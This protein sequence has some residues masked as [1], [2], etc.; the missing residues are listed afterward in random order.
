MN[1]EPRG[2]CVVDNNVQMKHRPAILEPGPDAFLANDPEP[3]VRPPR[4][5]AHDYVDIYFK[6][7]HPTWPFLHRGTFD[8]STEPCVLIQSIAM[9]GLWM[10]G[11]PKS[12]DAAMDFHNSLCS[13]IRT[14]MDR[15]QISDM[16]PRTSWPIPTYQSILLQIIFALFRA[17]KRGALDLNFRYLI[18]PDVYELLVAL[19]R[20]CRLGGIFSYPNMIT[21][22]S[23]ITTPALLWV[24]VEEIKRFG[25]A[26]YKVCRMTTCVESAGTH[27]DEDRSEL[28]TLED[29]C[30]GLPDSDEVWNSPPGT[31]MEVLE[32]IASQTKLRDNLDPTRWISQSS[33]VLYDGGI[34]FDWI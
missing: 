7:F 23:A 27:A 30:F 14:Q 21:H 25:L 33:S 6:D 9:M 16:T 3:A 32:K 31:G 8:L 12:Q 28:L 1:A 17:G 18:E 4:W 34:K 11:S 20:S 10:E 5:I 15:W 2:V 22:H 19:A 13:A 26:L 24:S 29:L